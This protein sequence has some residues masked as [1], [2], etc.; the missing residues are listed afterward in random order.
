MLMVV[1]YLQKDNLNADWFFNFLTIDW[2]ISSTRTHRWLK[3]YVSSVMLTS[4]ETVTCLFEYPTLSHMSLKSLL[5]QR[6][7]C[8]H[9][10]FILLP[11]SELHGQ[12][13]ITPEHSTQ[14]L[15]FTPCTTRFQHA[16][17][18]N[19]AHRVY[20][21]VFYQS[22]NKQWLFLYTAITD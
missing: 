17:I 5:F 7:I 14:S 22:Q 21:C 19:Y 18:L 12:S 8:R 9:C 11:V 1:W 4:S 2:N 10:V 20:F 16:E 15:L 13:V 3:S 6:F